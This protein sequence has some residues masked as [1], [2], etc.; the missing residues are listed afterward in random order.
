[1]SIITIVVVYRPRLFHAG[2]SPLNSAKRV[3]AECNNNSIIHRPYNG[4]LNNVK[5]KTKVENPK[6][7]TRFVSGGWGD[8]YHWTTMDDICINV[9]LVFSC[10]TREFNY[11]RF[12]YFHANGLGSLYRRYYNIIATG[13]TWFFGT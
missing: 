6:M 2:L 13:S 4:S 12:K 10:S 5:T 1:M 8:G 3:I 7:I 9:Y 11:T